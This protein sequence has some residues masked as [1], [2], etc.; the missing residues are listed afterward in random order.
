MGMVGILVIWLESFEQTF[1]PSSHWGSIWNLALNDPAVSE[2][3]FEECGQWTKQ[4]AYTISSP[5]EPKGSGELKMCQ[6]FGHEI[7]GSAEIYWLWQ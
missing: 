7:K 2:K 4:P 3:M 5:N 6:L 1:V